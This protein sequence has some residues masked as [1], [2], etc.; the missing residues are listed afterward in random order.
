M[1]NNYGKIAR[2]YVAGT[3]KVV[4]NKSGEPFEIYNNGR[5]KASGDTLFNAVKEFDEKRYCHD[6]IARAFE[7][8]DFY[9]EVKI[10]YDEDGDF[11]SFDDLSYNEQ[12]DKFMNSLTGEEYFDIVRDGTYDCYVNWNEIPDDDE[13]EENDEEDE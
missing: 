13:E 11:D 4:T 8:S 2:I 10:I 9:K 12:Y 3:Y 6:D 1:K 5:L 7:N